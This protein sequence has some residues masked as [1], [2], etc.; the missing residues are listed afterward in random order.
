MGYLNSDTIVVDAILTK[1]GRRELANGR[2]LSI[3]KF[4]LSDDGVDYSL[5]N[6][7]HPSG[8]VS[9]GQAIANLP[10][11]EA[12]PDDS[13]MMTY[14]LTT[15]DRH[16]KFLPKIELASGVEHIIFKKNDQGMVKKIQPVTRN[17]PGTEMFEAVLLNT[18]YVNM[19]GGA[20]VDIGGIVG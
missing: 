9:Y 17:Y 3:Q 14:K 6:V 12:T 16:L 5:Y 18:N 13:T 10:Q 2:G 8:S 11:L 1:H 19:A 7:D 15:M 20:A 4:A